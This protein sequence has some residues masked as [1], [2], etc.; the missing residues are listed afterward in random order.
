MFEP[1]NLAFVNCWL[2]LILPTGWDLLA[3]APF[4]GAFSLYLVFI[5]NRNFNRRR[6]AASTVVLQPA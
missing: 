6:S 2:V 1:F 3:T 5:N 4:S